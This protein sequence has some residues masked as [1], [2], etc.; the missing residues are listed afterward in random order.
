MSDNRARK[1]IA[2]VAAAGLMSDNRPRKV[3]AGVSAAGMMSDNLP[4]EFITRA[5]GFQLG[6]Y[7]CEKRL[8][9]AA[10]F[11]N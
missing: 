7:R 9:L 2:G 6:G 3:I 8:G 5:G 4:R 1:V 11:G 10:R